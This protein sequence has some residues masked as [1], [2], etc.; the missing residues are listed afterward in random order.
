MITLGGRVVV[1]CYD[2]ILKLVMPKLCL[3]LNDTKGQMSTTTHFSSSLNTEE[4]SREPGEAKIDVTKLSIY[5]FLNIC[6][7]C[8][9]IFFATP[10]Q[11]RNR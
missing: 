4:Y 2:G 1:C 6:L 3:K 10:P 9:T 7:N 5:D 11:S 8:L